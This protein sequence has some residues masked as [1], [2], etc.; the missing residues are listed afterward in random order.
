MTRGV[1]SRH[2]AEQ[3]PRKSV[4]NVAEIRGFCS[5]RNMG[6]ASVS[7]RRKATVPSN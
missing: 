5:E 2:G 3:K 1:R 6:G 7:V 4:E